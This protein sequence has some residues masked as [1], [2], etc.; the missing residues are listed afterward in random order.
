MKGED[1]FNAWRGQ[2]ELC[3]V[4]HELYYMFQTLCEM[5]RQEDRP[6][7]VDS[8]VKLK[9]VLANRW[10]QL[11]LHDVNAFGK[12]KVTQLPPK[13]ILRE[14]EMMFTHGLWTKPT[15]HKIP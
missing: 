14:F 13:E 4:K 6:M 5:E 9:Y 8:I 10:N 1:H 11:R 15:C 2:I 12:A 3:T 7:T